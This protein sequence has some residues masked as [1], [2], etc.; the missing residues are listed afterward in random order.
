M[1]GCIL[2]FFFLTIIIININKDIFAYKDALNVTHLANK[3]E[4]YYVILWG[5]N[6]ISH[7]PKVELSLNKK[8]LGQS[9]FDPERM[10]VTLLK[11][12]VPERIF[13]RC[14]EAASK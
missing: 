5:N 9:Q 14:H 2:H 1:D 11:A 13:S 7:H 4:Q 3:A 6:F 8:T 12:P 10:D